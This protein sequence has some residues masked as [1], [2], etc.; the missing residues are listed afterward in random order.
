MDVSPADN[1]IWGPREREGTLGIQG[2]QGKPGQ[3]VLSVN[4]DGD[5]NWPT[6][7][8]IIQWF[9]GLLLLVFQDWRSQWEFLE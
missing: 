8:E 4:V 7:P 6:Q 1:K 9:W 3:F 2:I 5:P